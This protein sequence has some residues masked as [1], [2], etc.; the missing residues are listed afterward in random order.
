MT[1]DYQE[2]CATSE[3]WC[4][5]YMRGGGECGERACASYGDKA[6]GHPPLLIIFVSWLFLAV[7]AWGVGGA[8]GCYVFTMPG[9]ARPCVS[10]HI[11]VFTPC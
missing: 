3:R 7:F 6:L 4:V 9:L 2:M 11:E 1:G 10:H 5:E 8:V